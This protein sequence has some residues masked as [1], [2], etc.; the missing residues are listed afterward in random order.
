[1][2][3]ANTSEFGVYSSWNKERPVAINVVES[4]RDLD[5]GFLVWKGGSVFSKLK[6]DGRWIGLKEW[7]VYGEARIREKCFFKY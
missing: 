2:N 5:A 3:L 6:V 4:A 7:E 1:M